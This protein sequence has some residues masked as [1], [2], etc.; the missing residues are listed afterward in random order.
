[1]ASVWIPSLMRDLTGGQERVTIPGATV[2]QV[3]DQLDLAY[4]GMKARLCNE[5]GEPLPSI[6]I[7]VDGE[8][9][10]EGLRAPVKPESEIYFLPAISGG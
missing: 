6:A 8:Q 2:R 9:V 7:A 4:P 3:I 1:M 10:I 5:S